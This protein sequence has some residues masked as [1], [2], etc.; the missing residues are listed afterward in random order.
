M[1]IYHNIYL[2]IQLYTAVIS[3]FLQC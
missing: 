3:L 1:L 2:T